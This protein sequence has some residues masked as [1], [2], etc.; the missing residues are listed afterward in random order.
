MIGLDTSVVVRYL[1]R[2]PETQA[3]AASAVIDGPDE[4]GI[5]V[6]VLLEAAHVLRTQYGVSRA[7]VLSALIDLITREDVRVLGLSTE[8]A[9]EAL[10][11]ARSL[12]GTPVADA[13]VVAMA[14]EAE[15]LPLYA[16]DRE[17]A[18]HGVEVRVP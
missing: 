2:R 8:H 10:V 1:V 6:V 16:F 17:M 5:S 15:A 7:D 14:R 4:L 9:L 12:P 3:M 18:R 11:R 13:L